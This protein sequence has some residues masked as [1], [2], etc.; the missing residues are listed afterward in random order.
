MSFNT[1]AAPNLSPKKAPLQTRLRSFSAA[2]KSRQ[3]R[4]ILQA[5][6]QLFLVSQ[7]GSTFSREITGGLLMFVCTL[8]ILTVH[9]AIQSGKLSNQLNQTGY[10]NEQIRGLTTSTA[11]VS[12]LA[13]SSMGLFSNTPIMIAPAMGLNSYFIRELVPI[14]DNWSGAL[15]VS[16]IASVVHLCIMLLLLT[17]RSLNLAMFVIPFYLRMGVTLGIGL[18]VAFIS[19]RENSGIGLFTVTNK[20]EIAFPAVLR[21]EPFLGML[22]VVIV[23]S[24]RR[25]EKLRNV[26][27]LIS[28]FLVTII[29][30]VVGSVQG[31]TLL[32]RSE[33]GDTGMGSLMFK[34]FHFSSLDYTSHIL[35]FRLLTLVIHK[36]FDSLLTLLA[37]AHTHI[38]S[39]K[40]LKGG[41]WNEMLFS[42]QMA[43]SRTMGR[44][45]VT[46]AVW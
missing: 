10:S 27:P 11:L 25:H 36:L 23:V 21:P 22:G 20:Q 5:L 1:T 19:L 46:D 39:R 32:K 33:W 18:M 17:T 4:T 7:R 9:P 34:C 2:V 43:E 28:V 13:T 3:R 30:L 16:F 14:A 42:R 12:G 38:L 41:V 31:Q 6:D 24:L 44:I 45:L 26:A 35:W 8:Y 40:L 15:T 37:M 29:S